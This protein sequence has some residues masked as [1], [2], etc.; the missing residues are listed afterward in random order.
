M[1]IISMI[2]FSFSSPA[3]EDATFGTMDGITDPQPSPENLRQHQGDQSSLNVSQIEDVVREDSR[4][5]EPEVKGT[6]YEETESPGLDSDDTGAESGVTPDESNEDLDGDHIMT[7]PL[8]AGLAAPEDCNKDKDFYR[9]AYRNA[10]IA[11]KHWKIPLADG[12]VHSNWHR[13]NWDKI[14]I[15]EASVEKIADFE[16][17][18]FAHFINK[19]LL[20]REARFDLEDIDALNDEQK[21][22]KE[23]LNR[24]FKHFKQWIA[25]KRFEHFLQHCKKPKS[26]IGKDQREPC[27][28]PH[29]VACICK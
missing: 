10:S 9:D 11:A 28:S 20:E 29:M 14:L 21:S 22:S 6:A 8:R 5:S 2:N 18:N 16:E 13:D 26:F 1:D 4:E 19:L 17:I 15:G 24:E 7:W 27:N 3:P 25:G 23:E 12:T